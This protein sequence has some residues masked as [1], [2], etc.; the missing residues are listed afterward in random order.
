MTVSYLS[1][2]PRCVGNCAGPTQEVEIIFN[3]YFV[4]E[5]CVG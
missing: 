5:K 1:W 2:V 3:L 4:H